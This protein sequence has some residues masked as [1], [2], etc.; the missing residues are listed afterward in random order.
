MILTAGIL[1]ALTGVGAGSETGRLHLSGD[2]PENNINRDE[3]LIRKSAKLVHRI[4]RTT[5]AETN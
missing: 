3:Q 2:N 1:Y 4:M 5:D